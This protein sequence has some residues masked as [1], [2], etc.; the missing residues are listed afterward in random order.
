MPRSRFRMTAQKVERLATYHAMA[1]VGQ[2]ILGMLENGLPRPEFAGAQFAL[3]QANDFQN[4]QLKTGISLYL[5]HVAVN[6]SHRNRAP[7]LGSDGKRYRPSMPLD[8]HYLLTAWAETAVQQQ[9]LLGWA[10][11]EVENTP[12]MH[13][14]LLNHHGSEPETFRSSEAVE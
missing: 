5:Y 10:M 7:R 4:P 1:A 8:L 14:G 11:R 13:A 6:G 2:T 12:I 3:F 9:R